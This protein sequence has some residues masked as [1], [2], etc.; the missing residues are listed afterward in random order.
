MQKGEHISASVIV[1]SSFNANV[2]EECTKRSC[3]TRM[4]LRYLNG[5]QHRNLGASPDMLVRIGL[6]HGDNMLG[7]QKLLALVLSDQQP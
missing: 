1:L 7:K 6:S 4:W 3:R 5:A 2:L